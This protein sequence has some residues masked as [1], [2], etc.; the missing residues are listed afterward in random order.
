LLATESESVGKQDAEAVFGP[1]D[2][3]V[4]GGWRS[5]IDPHEGVYTHT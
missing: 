1:Q 2:E 5:F 3:E 4:T